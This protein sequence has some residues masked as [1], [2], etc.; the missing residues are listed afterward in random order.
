MQCASGEAHWADGQVVLV[1]VR[2]GR[3]GLLCGELPTVRLYQHGAEPI[4][5]DRPS[6]V[7]DLFPP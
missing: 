7:D 1:A 2:S 4:R 5:R 6:L 3:G